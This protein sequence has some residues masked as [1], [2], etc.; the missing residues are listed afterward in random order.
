MNFI[1]ESISPDRDLFR[2][3]VH[4]QCVA[5]ADVGDLVGDDFDQGG[6]LEMRLLGFR[7]RIID[8]AFIENIFG[9]G[10]VTSD[11]L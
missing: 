2:V 7:V 8:P 4:F 11:R 3:Q 1:E 10:Q 9:S 5:V 6:I